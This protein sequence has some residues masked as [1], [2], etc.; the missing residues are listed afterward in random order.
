MTGAPPPA[1]RAAPPAARAPLRQKKNMARLTA[2]P[3]QP[4]PNLAA[5]AALPAAKARARPPQ[6]ARAEPKQEEE[7]LLLSSDDEDAAQPAAAPAERVTPES[8][9][10]PFRTLPADDPWECLVRALL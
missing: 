2:Q 7:V 8:T 10:N 5:P 3:R 1:A 6:R 9:S 4:L